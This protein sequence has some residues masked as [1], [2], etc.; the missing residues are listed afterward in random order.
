[1]NQPARNTGNARSAAASSIADVPLMEIYRHQSRISA[2][3]IAIRQG[4]SGGKFQ[5]NYWP[6]TGQE[7]IPAA[8]APNLTKN[9]YL[10]TT[11]RGVHDHIAK[12]VPLRGLFAEALGRAVGLNKGKG[13][14]AHLTDPGTG[15]MLT[16]AIVGSGAPIANG[17]AL[18][19]K[20]RGTD[21]VSVV[22]FGDGA[23]SIGA[24]HEALNLA[25]AWKLPV[26]FLL[27]NNGIG[28]YT[29]VPGYTATRQF[30]DRAVGY[31][32]KGIRVDGNDPVAM[33]RA[34]K[35]AVDTCRS[36]NGPVF[37]EAVTTRLG[38]HYGVAPTNHLPKEQLD[39]AKAAEPISRTRRLIIENAIA[40]AEQ[41]D[42]IDAESKADVQEAITWALA[43]EPTEVNETFKDV[44][45]DSTTFPDPA[46]KR[47]AVASE[48]GAEGPTAVM[49]MAEA[50]CSAQDVAMAANR[51]VIVLGEDVG[52]PPGGVYLTQKGLQAKYGADRILP[53]PIAE[54]AIIGA[55]IGAAL[56][57]MRP[58]CEIMFSDFL[59]VCIDQIANH[60][61]KQRY[62][63]GGK[64]HV[65]MTIRVM[66]GPNPFGGNGAQHSQS[67]E[68]WLLH[69]PGLK[70]IYPS[71]AREAK[72][73]LASCILDDDPTV[74][75]ESCKLMHTNKGQVPLGDF[76][77][78]LGVADVKR[79]GKDLS[80]I[81]YGWQVH[82]ALAAAETVAAEGIDVE[83][84]DLRSL[85]PLDYQTVFESVRKTRRALVLHAATR[86]CGFGAE[87]AST[88]AEVMHGELKGPVRRMGGEFT[89]IAFAK[90]LEAVQM[91]RAAAVTDAMRQIMTRGDR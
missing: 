77:I 6:M 36:G 25:G 44:Y 87:I 65:P 59:G 9:D 63:S 42:A 43:Q 50:I 88:I 66:G 80:V 64:S 85:L 72:G 40:T 19:A 58:I 51:E 56:A 62:M 73:L 12:G 76:R 86:F 38:A 30:V 84:V 74:F 27:Q 47:P 14:T 78:P 49:S 70:V 15:S 46:S 3:D 83:V 82:E 54:T 8:L 41:L 68:S 22:S 69:I 16:T 21:R 4:I 26:V 52:D 39:A 17:L 24:V 23:T 60:A 45:T 55:G 29:L 11:Y 5:F 48:T 37:L 34:A 89:P 79:K 31:G 10:V 35:D 18:A 28:E 1:M 32:I 67:L 91:P 13:G 7:N 53:T 33:Y 57:G 75:L 20:F 2:V 61:A 71:T 90:A 81:T